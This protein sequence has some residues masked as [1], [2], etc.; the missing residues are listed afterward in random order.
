MLRFAALLLV[1]PLL[2]GCVA[3]D[4]GGTARDVA[5]ASGTCHLHGVPMSKERVSIIY[6]LVAIPMD[7]AYRAQISKFPFAHRE[8]YGG[9]AQMEVVGPPG[10]PDLSSP[11]YAD[12]QICTR[13][14]AAKARWIFWHPWDPWAKTWRKQKPNKAE[15]TLISVTAPAVQQTHRP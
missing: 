5:I 11:I 6:G 10:Y 7:A 12:I 13:C 9:C 2:A 4:I 14:D 3:M 8:V 1:I 15:P